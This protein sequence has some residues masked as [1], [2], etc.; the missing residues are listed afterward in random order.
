MDW[1]IFFSFIVWDFLFGNFED[2][3]GGVY[4]LKGSWEVVL[5][6]VVLAW[7]FRMGSN[8]LCSLGSEDEGYLA[9]SGWCRSS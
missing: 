7:D 5:L 6:Q 2:G 8:L 3:D 9:W 1:Y 4:G